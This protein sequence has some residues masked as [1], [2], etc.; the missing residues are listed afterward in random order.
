VALTGSNGKTT[1]K[2]MLASILAAH[3]RVRRCSPPRATSTTTSA[4]RSRC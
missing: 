2:E 3:A 4:C 1:V